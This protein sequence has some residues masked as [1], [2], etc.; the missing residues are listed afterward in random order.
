VRPPLLVVVIVRAPEVVGVY[1]KV[2]ARAVPAHVRLTGSN[3]PPTP[4][5]EGMIVPVKT[6]PVGVI[7]KLLDATLTAPDDGP[8]SV[9]AVANGGFDV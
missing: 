7:V 4:L 8:V 2:C 9:Y 6:P 5:S 3:V 1:V